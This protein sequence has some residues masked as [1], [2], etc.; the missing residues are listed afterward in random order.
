MIVKGVDSSSNSPSVR[1]N[2]LAGAAVMA[3]LSA[4]SSTS[5][6]LMKQ[7]IASMEQ[8]G[9]MNGLIEGMQGAGMQGY[10]GYEPIISYLNAMMPSLSG[11]A[12]AFAKNILSQLNSS[13]AKKEYTDVVTDSNLLNNDPLKGQR[14]AL[15]SQ[16]DNYEAELGSTVGQAQNV[17]GEF[18]NNSKLSQQD[19]L[20]IVKSVLNDL[21]N[22]EG[23]TKDQCSN[24]NSNN[25]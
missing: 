20:E 10:N 18:L 12:K 22:L 9:E 4:L 8:N 19:K 6:K 3:M 5:Q 1:G 15:E 16:L 23:L 14:K 21:N 17:A 2:V 24:N 13:S 11:Q 25:K 7:K